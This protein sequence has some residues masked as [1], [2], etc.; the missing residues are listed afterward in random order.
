[1][2]ASSTDRRSRL[3]PLQRCCLAAIRAAAAKGHTGHETALVIGH[4]RYSTQPRLTELRGKGL[5][6]DSGRRRVNPSGRRAI[7][8]VAAEYLDH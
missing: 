2:K 6:R 3:G 8:W 1:M 7:V 5:I 4:D